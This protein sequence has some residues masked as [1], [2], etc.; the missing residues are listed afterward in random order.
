MPITD[1]YQGIIDDAHSFYGNPSNQPQ[2]Y[3]GPTVAGF[4][5][6]QE[7]AFQGFTNAANL[8]QGLA[9]GLA[10]A[11]QQGLQGAY[12]YNPAQWNATSYQNPFLQQQANLLG[13]QATAGAQQGAAG[14]GTLGGARAARAG[15]EAATRATTP[16]YAGAYDQWYGAQNQANAQNAQAQNAAAQYNLNNIYN[17][18][19][20]VPQAQRAAS[21]GAQ[22]LF[23]IGGVQQQ[24]DQ[25]IRDEDIKRFNYAQ[26][27]PG[28]QQQQLLGLG[29]LQQGAQ[30][31]YGSQPG[32]NIFD[33]P[34]GYLK[35]TFS[36]GINNYLG[37][38]IG[39]F[40]PFNEGSMGVDMFNGGY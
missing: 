19:G 13:Q 27:Q 3:S 15:A 18:A 22:T 21:Q 14:A 33:D 36:R 35:N 6:P 7:Q 32:F 17:W 11:A 39:N 12:S 23:D 25:R 40:L 2:Y 16:L 29:A 31:G 9:G 37:N 20:Q 10:G 34:G 8:Q 4:T 38:A 30:G 5:Q 26:T 1:F 28:L 24:H